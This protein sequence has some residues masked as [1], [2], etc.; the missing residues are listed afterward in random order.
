M[1]RL[2]LTIAGPW[3]AAPPLDLGPL[4]LEFGPTEPGLADEMADVAAATG[5]FDKPELKALRKHKGV[6]FISAEVADGDLAPA[7]AAAR[8][9]VDAFAAGALGAYI[10]TAGKVLSPAGVIGL[11]PTDGPTL[12]HLFVEVYREPD[13]ALTEGMQAFGLRDVEVLCGA[14]AEAAAAQAATFGLAA[15]MVCDGVRPGLGHPFRASESAPLFRVA[16]GDPVVIPESRDE[17]IFVNPLG[18]WRLV[19]A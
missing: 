11:D 10:E 6:L 16:D 4:D 12:F 2:I 17:A 1:A 3:D 9:I 8:V 15:R 7:R 19:R 5:A 14:E 13:R 18:R